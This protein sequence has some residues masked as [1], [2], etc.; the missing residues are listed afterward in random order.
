MPGTNTCEWC[1]KPPSRGVKP[2]ERAARLE[3]VVHEPH[4]HR[5]LADRGGD[6]LDRAAAHVARGEHAGQAGLEQ[7]RL[8][9]LLAARRGV[10]PVRTNPLSSSATCPP[11]QPVYGSAPMKT[12]SAR[13]S[14]LR[15]SPVRR[16][17]TTSASSALVADQFAHLGAGQHLDAAGALDPVDE[18]ARH[19]A[20]QVV[21]ANEQ[22]YPCGAVL[23]QEEGRLA[24]RVATADHRHRR[25]PRHSCASISVAA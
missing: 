5:A 6:A 12:N 7:R 25:R 8:G 17:S 13:A 9:A 15:C 1:D 23:G 19:V 2:R 18:V 10:G 16:S 21:V 3:V 11:S 24:G 20:A 4:G 14:I 22:A